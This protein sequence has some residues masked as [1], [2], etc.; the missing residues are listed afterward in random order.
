MANIVECLKNILS[1]R[2]GKDVRQSIHDGIKKINDEV[3]DYGSVAGAKA[4]EA[5]ASAEAAAESETNSKAS[6]TASKTSETNAK[7]SE[8]ASKAS[9]TAAA[10]SETNAENYAD[11]S[12]SYAVGGTGTR[13]GEDTDNAKYYK[14]QA[15]Q[16]VVGIQGGFIPMGTISF[17]QLASQSAKAGYMYNI[18]DDFTS[19]ATFKDGAGIDYPAGTNVYYTADNMWDCLTGAAVVG[20]KGNK[21]SA[22]RK[23]V[24]NITPENIG[25][26]AENATAASA[27]KAEQDGNGNV[28]TDT[29]ATKTELENKADDIAYDNNNN[30]LQLKSGDT[31]LQEVTISDKVANDKI[32]EIEDRILD[33]KAEI[34]ACTESNMI[35]G[36]LAVKAISANVNVK[37]SSYNSSTKTLN[38][39]SV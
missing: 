5:A 19:D 35:A 15:Q 27:T 6:E 32:A 36:A 34:E 14:E 18:S 38:L 33:S 31:V 1:A 28:I 21:E 29:Y 12:K 13:E 30:K 20:V 16:I 10:E 17:A 8:T 7:A 37:V 23:G 26:L 3:V 9:E 4:E 2:Y 25:A 11:A 22:Y 39:V 24:V